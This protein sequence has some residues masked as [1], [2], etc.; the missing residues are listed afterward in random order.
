MEMFPEIDPFDSPTNLSV[1]LLG[2]QVHYLQSDRIGIIPNVGYGNEYNQSSSAS[3]W[4]ACIVEK[5]G[6][7]LQT[8]RSPGLGKYIGNVPGDGQERPTE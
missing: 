5:S 3:E 8:C 1:L 6:D 4:V 7:R 2:F